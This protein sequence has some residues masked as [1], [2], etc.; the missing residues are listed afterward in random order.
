MIEFPLDPTVGQE[1]VADNAVTY[2]WSGSYW[3]SAPALAAGTARFYLDGG[4]ATTT[5][6]DQELDGG[7]A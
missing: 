2:T 6:F 5:Y 3:S 1:Y 4:R 7:T